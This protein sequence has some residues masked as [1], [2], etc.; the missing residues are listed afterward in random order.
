MGRYIELDLCWVWMS[1]N[2]SSACSAS[3]R[4]ICP[5]LWWPFD[6]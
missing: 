1:Q 6:L 2:I 4:F 5:V 3:T